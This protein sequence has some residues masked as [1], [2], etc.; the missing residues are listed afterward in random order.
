M[1]RD[2]P[3]TARP[4]APADQDESEE[5]RQTA[6]HRCLQILDFAEAY[7]RDFCPS[8][9]P[10]QVARTVSVA[11]SV[12]ADPALTRQLVHAEV[13]LSAADGDDCP[14]PPADGD[15]EFKPLTF[16]I[17]SLRFADGEQ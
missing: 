15:A 8:T 4:P 1:W 14:E 9:E 3:L 2:H 10:P 7:R 17:D 11:S 12:A 5:I 13:L 6:R 16:S